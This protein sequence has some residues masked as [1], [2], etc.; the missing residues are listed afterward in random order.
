MTPA[1]LTRLSR[2]AV[3]HYERHRDYEDIL[4]TAHMQAWR[5]FQQ[6]EATGQPIR[7]AVIAAAKRAPVE[8]FRSW[9]G[10]NHRHS[11]ANVCGFAD[12]A[13]RDAEAEEEWEPAAPGFE[14][15]LLD[16]LEAEAI[17][18]R[19]EELC[20]PGE[21][22]AVRRV[23][24]NQESHAEVSRDLGLHPRSAYARFTCAVQRYHDGRKAGRAN[25]QKTHCPKGHSY[26]EHGVT[27]SQGRKCRVCHRE[28]VKAR[29]QYRQNGKTLP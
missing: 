22:E 14:A 29:R 1:E 23:V 20:S 21:L 17:W 5:A 13:P 15:A 16:R 19:L 3:R 12:L 4:A 9:L 6:A 25:S 11:E 28:R 24:L 26:A 7:G 18:E 8:W 2:W 10:R 27:S